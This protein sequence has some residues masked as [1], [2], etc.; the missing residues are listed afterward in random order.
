[1]WLLR[2]NTSREIFNTYYVLWTQHILYERC[3]KCIVAQGVYFEGLYPV[4][5]LL[6][7]Q[8]CFAF[9]FELWL[10]INKIYTLSNSID[11]KRQVWPMP[12]TRLSDHDSRRSLFRRKEKGQGFSS[13]YYPGETKDKTKN[14]NWVGPIARLE[15]TWMSIVVI[16]YCNF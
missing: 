1:M 3:Q 15:L 7:V 8:L 10:L 16:I 4:F 5:Y 6:Y 13:R 12:T 14:I 2:L 11:H 9:V